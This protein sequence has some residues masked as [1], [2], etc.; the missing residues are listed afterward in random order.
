MALVNDPYWTAMV[1]FQDRDKNKSG[2]SFYLP[3]TL[4]YADAAA[5]ATFIAQ[6]A[7]PISS[8][9]LYS[10]SLTQTLY[11]AVAFA[12]I[13]PEDSDV[14][15]K[16]VFQFA[17][18]QRG[19]KTRIEVPSIMNQFVVDGSNVLNIA[20]PLVA[21]FQAAILN[22]GLGANNSP[23]TLGGVDITGPFGTPY[24][25]HRGSSKG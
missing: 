2:F 24:K 3:S 21:A 19:I 20:D 23:I 4:L 13:A 16:G 17:T 6:A 25:M 7:D 14:E 9:V 11:D 8:G 1:S 18:A 22:T 10:L 5:A 12:T 15:R